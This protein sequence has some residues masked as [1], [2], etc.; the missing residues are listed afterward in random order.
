MLIQNLKDLK[1]SD[2]QSVKTAAPQ[3]VLM[4]DPK[5]FRV[6][7]A[8][9][10]FMKDEQ[11]NLKKVDS[12]KAIREWNE[13]KATYEKLGFQVATLPG[14]KSLPDMVFTANQSMPFLDKEKKKSVL[15]S[16]MYSEFRRKEVN[17]FRQWYEEN[18]YKIYT[19][20]NKGFFEG[21]GDAL[22]QYPY[23]TVWGGYGH[24]TSKEVY[25]EIVE[26]FDLPVIM[27]NMIRPEFYHLDTCFSI[28]NE[29]TVVL[30]SEAFEPEALRMIHEV[31]SKVIPTDLEE[32]LKYFCCNCHSPNGVQVIS[33]KGTKKFRA[34]MDKAGF[35]LMEVDTTEYL[36]SGGSVF[37]MK[38]MAF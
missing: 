31:F 5:H 20:E 32:N 30:Q 38:M 36:K 21:N 28:L 22:I 33:H 11:G 2:I 18:D 37:C 7:Y 12:V 34:D 23:R 9:N 17:Y 10:P 25:R 24:R 35:D 8:I 3:K 15:L 6:E 29:N 16:H 26:R 27:L 19:L 4:S 14:E 1:K 13:L